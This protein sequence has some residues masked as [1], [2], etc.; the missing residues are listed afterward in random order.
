M[1]K[2][3]LMTAWV[4]QLGAKV[5]DTVTGFKG[6]TTARIEYLNGCRQYCVESKLDKEGKL[7]KAPYVDEGQLELL[8]IQPPEIFK[9]DKE[10][11]GGRMPNEPE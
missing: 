4:F 5:K 7:Q 2:K 6:T 8:G 10:A 3:P 11:P 1:K 9:E